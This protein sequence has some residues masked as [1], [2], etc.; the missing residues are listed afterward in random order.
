MEQN[1]NLRA[2]TFV[3]IAVLL[4]G[5]AGVIGR[6]VTS[7][8]FVVTFGRVFVSSTILF[9]LI[10][11]TKTPFKIRNIKDAIL[12]LIAGILMAI[13]WTAFMHTAQVA[14][15]AMATITF[16]TFPLFITFIE[17]LLFHEKL[18]KKDIFMALGILLGVIILVPFG[19]MQANVFQGIIWGMVSSGTYALLSL[20]NRRLGEHYDSKTVCFYEQAI[21]TLILLPFLLTIPFSI[22]SKDIVLIFLLGAVC[23]AFA[24]NLF[25]KSL[26]DIRVQT[27]GI[28]SSMETVYGIL[29]AV[30]LLGET[31]TLREILGG[32]IILGVTFLSTYLASVERKRNKVNEKG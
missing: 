24:H 22:P 8:A 27:A 18:A 29:L 21:A 16:S 10:Q 30:L 19:N 28:I 4:F 23:T 14:G 1:S 12:F 20:C 9:I 13:H 6:G 32:T 17:P 26:K 3:H 15:V 7:P 31:P 25:V 11:V 2:L 5:L